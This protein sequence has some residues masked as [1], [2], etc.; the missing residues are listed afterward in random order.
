MYACTSNQEIAHAVDKTVVQSLSV[1]PPA[2]CD[3]VFSV[4]RAYFHP[5]GA[6]VTNHSRYEVYQLP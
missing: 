1:V 3:Q 5:T 6:I 2:E 4:C